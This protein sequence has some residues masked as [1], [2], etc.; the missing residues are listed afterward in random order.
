MPK[1]SNEIVKI[2]SIVLRFKSNS[3]FS[4]MTSYSMLKNHINLV[5][6]TSLSATTSINACKL[7]QNSSILSLSRGHCAQGACTCQLRSR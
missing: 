4:Y 1:L 2:A 6:L 7:T 5:K 3:P